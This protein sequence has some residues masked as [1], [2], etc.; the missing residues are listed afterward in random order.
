MLNYQIGVD[1]GKRQGAGGGGV[2]AWSTV[3]VR[4][5][6][7]WRRNTVARRSYAEVPW[8]FLYFLPEPQGQGSFRPT[9]AAARTGFGASACAGP[10]WYCRF[11][12]C[13]RWR[14]SISL[15]E[16]TAG[17]GA[18]VEMI[19]HQVSGYAAQGFLDAGDLRDDVGTIAIVFDHFL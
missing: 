18:V 14:R 3:F 9:L 1:P 4:I 19:A 7:S 8:H 5:D 12:C 13:L 2:T 11:C 15:G 6:G 17:R 16:K 10:V